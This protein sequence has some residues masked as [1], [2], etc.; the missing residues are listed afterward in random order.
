MTVTSW[1]WF[2]SVTTV[3]NNVNLRGELI[4]QYWKL[5]NES[6]YCKLYN[7]AGTAYFIFAAKSISCESTNIGAALSNDLLYLNSLNWNASATLDVGGTSAATYY[8]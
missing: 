7:N 1:I 4:N 6:D 2:Y 3:S 8:S 5:A